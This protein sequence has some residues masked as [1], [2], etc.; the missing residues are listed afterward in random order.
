MTSLQVHLLVYS[1]S[2]VEFSCYNFIHEYRKYL[3]RSPKLF[4]RDHF[5]TLNTA[6]GVH[7]S[8]S[9]VKRLCIT[10]YRRYKD[11]NYIS[12]NDD[13]ERHRHKLV[14]PSTAHPFSLDSALII[15]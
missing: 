3:A 14:I 7:I 5:L 13:I 4:N 12:N 1:L 11:D 10:Q 6:S 8:S 15:R 2:L 9:T